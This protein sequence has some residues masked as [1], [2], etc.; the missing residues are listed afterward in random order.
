[1]LLASEPPIQYTPDPGAINPWD[2]P[3]PIPFEEPLPA[4]GWTALHQ[5]AEDGD[6]AAVRRILAL[7]SAA[8]PT[9]ALG[10]TPL[11]RACSHGSVAVV[12]ALLAAGAN[13]DSKG[14]H[15]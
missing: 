3:P 2:E 11:L 14:L 10:D 5:A 12:D 6:L 1:M 4:P 7:G 15:R 13:P 9:D 8:D